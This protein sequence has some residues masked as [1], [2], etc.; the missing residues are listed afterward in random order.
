[1][2]D[3]LIGY[4]GFVGSN[5]LSRHKFNKLYDINNISEI[6]G[7]QF[8]LVVCAGAP[9]IKWKANKY[10]QK[11]RD[12]IN[13]L[14]KNLAK[15]KTKKIILISTIDV[16]P[17]VDK[18]N[19]DS[20]IDK[21]K[22]NFYGKHRRILEEFI[23]SHFNST[24]IRLPG[25]FG[26]GLKGNVIY[27]LLNKRYEYVP[28]NGIMQF[29]NLDYIWIDINI[30]I[31]NNLSV[32]NLSTE[33]LS[34]KTITE[35]IFHLDINYISNRINKAQYYNMQT[36]HNYLWKSEIPYLYYKEHIL[37]DLKLF[38]KKINVERI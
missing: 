16:Y 30:A 2:N 38:I 37:R 26:K 29:Y 3:A 13:Y 5:I 27:D 20:K 19:E 33:P 22:L 12:N 9:G 10:P 7:K 35:E 4:S 36:K 6:E 23:E 34:I 21:S 8:D 11:D 17:N 25:L 14:I 1:M 18:V 31:Q 32:I 28:K 15:V 24:I